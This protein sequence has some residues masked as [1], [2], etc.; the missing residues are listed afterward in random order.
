[1]AWANI[2]DI[3]PEKMERYFG[4]RWRDMVPIAEYV[5]ALMLADMIGEDEG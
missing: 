4:P 5:A 2:D 1:M 3:E